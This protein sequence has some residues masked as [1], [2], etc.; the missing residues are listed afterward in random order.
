MWH[1]QVFGDAK[2]SLSILFIGFLEP[3]PL[4]LDELERLVTFNSFHWI[5]FNV[6]IYYITD[7]S[8]FQ[9]FS[10]DS[11]IA[12]LEY[13]QR[14]IGVILSILFIGFEQDLLRA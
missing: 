9:F 7:E 2:L 6:G 11:R 14:R 3:K 8:I 10:L 5:P 4:P 13:R 12:E 1:L